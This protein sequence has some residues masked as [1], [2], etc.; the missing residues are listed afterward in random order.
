MS[1]NLATSSG[2]TGKKAISRSTRKD[3][4]RDP[5]YNQL[6]MYA[7]LFRLLGWLHSTPDSALLYTF[8]LLGEQVVKAGR[9]W[10]PLFRETVLGIA[11]PNH[12][13]ASQT[14]Q[15]IRPFATILR[16]MLSCNHG[17]SRDEMIV[18]PLS[19]ASDRN[20]ADLDALSESINALR[21]EPGAIPQAIEELSVQRGVQ[22]NTLRNYTRWPIA[23]MRDLGW[24][25]KDREPYRQSTRTFEI[26]RL[27]PRGEATAE[28]LESSFDVRV[29]DI[30]RLPDDQIRA[31][32]RHTHFAMMERSG[33]DL[34]SVSDGLRED[35]AQYRAA[36]KALGAPR[37]KPLLFSPFQSLSDAELVGIFPHSPNSR[38]KEPA[39]TAG[40]ELPRIPARVI[41][42]LLVPPAFVSREV[43]VDG[44][45]LDKLRATLLRFRQA[46]RTSEAAADAF[47]ESRRTDT[48]TEF[49]P[50][51]TNLMRLIGYRS[52]PSRPGDNYQRWD[53]CVWLKGMA[54]PMEIKSPTEE[55]LLSTKAVRQA[56]ENKVILLARGA[57]NTR[58][59][60][61]TLIV[62]FQ[63]PNE[64]GDMAT[65]ID[66]IHATFGISIGVLDLRALGL[67]ALRSVTESLSI[68][69]NQL[70]YLKGFLDV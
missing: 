21:G 68:D 11:Y 60:M 43:D 1:A 58:R 64:R 69:E 38:V 67:L 8:T 14:D 23:I 16:T 39:R 17:L 28:Y 50:L 37:N 15:S 32:S 63:L 27:T 47:R 34:S 31:V 46:Q 10:Q 19:V 56:L 53:A 22:V 7:E 3:R 35:E 36:L 33:F 65:L 4:S 40:M 61:T 9:N 57:L 62:G 70:A 59:D 24:T 51:V 41:H 52:A 2:Y 55:L 5:L 66:D 25:T 49:Y 54:V 26:H 44:S 20:R 48:Q 45:E 29:T 13:I 6:K 30:A 12:V 18:G 42:H